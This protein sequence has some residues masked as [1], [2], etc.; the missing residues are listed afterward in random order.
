MRIKT[1]MI[2]MSVFIFTLLT[3]TSCWE[4]FEVVYYN[5]SDETMWI[6][7]GSKEYMQ[8]TYGDG[9]EWLVECPPHI[10]VDGRT[11]EFSSKSEKKEFLKGPICVIAVSDADY[12][13]RTMEEIYAEGLYEYTEIPGREVEANN[14]LIEYPFEQR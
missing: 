3:S 13:T 1:L 11:L 6:G 7:Y 10:F 9:K 2:L 8:P 4:V 5:G 14:C 12:K